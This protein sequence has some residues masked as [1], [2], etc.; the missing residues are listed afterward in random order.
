M[1][2]QYCGV[3]FPHDIGEYCERT[4]RDG[5]F[6]GCF[7][8]PFLYE[9][10]QELRTGNP[11]ELL[12]MPPGTSIY[13]GPISEQE[14]FR[15]DWIYLTGEDLEALLAR[16]PIPEQVAFGIGKPYLLRDCIRRVEEELLL[17][18]EGYEEVIAACITEAIISIY[19]LYRRQQLSQSPM[20]RIE[21]VREAFLLHPQEEWTLEKMAGMCG[22]SVSRFCALY[23]QRFGSS[24]KA[25]LL[26]HRMEQA[27]QMLRYS[28]LSIAE[29]AERCGFGSIYYFSRYFKEQEGCTPSEYSGKFLEITS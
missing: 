25:E 14:A 3:D 28:D 26:A 2:V 15:N 11:G 16:Y 23:T 27:R 4:V 12:L 29:V 21:S 9:K 13:H 10:G 5:Y 8:T 22:Y 19:R 1:V 18:Q 20:F 17:K 24:P 6:L 7:V